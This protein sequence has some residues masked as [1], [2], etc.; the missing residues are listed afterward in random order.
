MSYTSNIACQQFSIPGAG[1]EI[2]AVAEL[3]EVFAPPHHGPRNIPITVEL[4]TGC[5][6]S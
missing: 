3:S 6:H 2:H 5:D 4:L 1:E